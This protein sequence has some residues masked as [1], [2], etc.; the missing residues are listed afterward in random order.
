MMI[1]VAA[2]NYA[3]LAWAR[4]PRSTDPGSVRLRAVCLRRRRHSAL[5]ER[6]LELL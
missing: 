1:L 3:P 5:G 6:I 2:G 4:A